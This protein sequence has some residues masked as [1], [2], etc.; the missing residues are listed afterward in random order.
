MFLREDEHSR[1]C[2]IDLAQHTLICTS[3]MNNPL[4]SKVFNPWNTTNKDIPQEMIEKI[5]RAHGWRGKLTNPQIFAQA[6]VH[7][8]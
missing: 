1:A 4:E 2:K 3:K 5:L 7:K 6:C 8:S